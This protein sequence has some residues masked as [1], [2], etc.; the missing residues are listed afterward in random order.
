MTLN[1]KHK[2]PVMRQLEMFGGKNIMPSIVMEKMLG[3]PLELKAKLTI[4]KITLCPCQ[5]LTTALIK[6]ESEASFTT[7]PLQNILP[8]IL[9]RGPA[10]MCCTVCLEEANRMQTS[11][12]EKFCRETGLKIYAINYTLFFNIV[13][14]L[15]YCTV[16]PI[17]YIVCYNHSLICL[18]S[19]NA[20]YWSGLLWI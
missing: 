6:T 10:C 4:R 11:S 17:Y 19:L 2:L 18:S 15:K 8:H 7:I 3:V 5:C 12:Q 13:H 14:Y 1:P 20:L 16:N 9:N